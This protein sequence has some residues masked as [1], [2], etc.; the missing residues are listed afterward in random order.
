MGLA[1]ARKLVPSVYWAMELATTQRFSEPTW[2]TP[3]SM[4]PENSW[5]GKAKV[6]ENQLNGRL[7]LGL[8]ETDL[9][10]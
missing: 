3:C 2:D 10:F 7:V 5:S 1:L 8:G 9:Q 4:N 6:Q